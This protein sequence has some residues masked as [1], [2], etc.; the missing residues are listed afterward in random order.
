MTE[1][2]RIKLILLATSLFLSLVIAE[3]GLRLSTEPTRFLDSRANEYWQVRLHEFP[4]RDQK[5][6]EVR[7]DADLGWRMMPLLRGNSSMDE[8]LPSREHESEE[9]PLEP[10]QRRI[11][12]IGNSYTYGFGVDANSTYTTLLGRATNSEA[13]NAGSNSYGLDQSILLWEREAAS[14]EPDVVIL[15]YLVDGFFRNMLHTRDRPKPYFEFDE[16]ARSFRLHNVPVPDVRDPAIHAR[17][18]RAPSW[19][20]PSALAWGA[21]RAMARFGH[22]DQDRLERGQALSTFLL[23]RMRDSVEASGAR[24]IVAI[25]GTCQ[26]FDAEYLLIEE[27]IMET[28]RTHHMECLNTAELMRANDYAS[29]FSSNCHFSEEGHHLVANELS[30]VLETGHDR[31]EEPQPRGRTAPPTTDAT[32]SRELD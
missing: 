12:S 29:Y 28:C 9:A 18:E 31:L 11:L 22:V 20:L 21:R 1:R 7:Y 32:T 19:R 2:R 26:Q 10:R 17:I 23:R 4:A 6:N 5:N 24:L 27:A 13:I 16:G 15:G 30:A 14:L 3:T 25:F 8:A